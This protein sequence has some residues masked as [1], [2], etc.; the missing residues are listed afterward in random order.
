MRKI[1]MLFVIGFL[2]LN[3]SGFSQ[4]VVK[5]DSVAYEKAKYLKEDLARFLAK[6]TRYPISKKFYWDD[7]YNQE[8]DV[9]FS[10]VINKNSELENLTLESSTENIL[11]ECAIEAL[12]KL[13]KKWS[14]TKINHIS[15]DKKYKIIFRFRSFLDS[16]PPVYEKEIASLVKRHQYDK[17]IKLYDEQIY[18]NPCDFE[19]FA[20]RSKLKGKSGDKIGTIE[21][22]KWADK[23]ND[24]Y[25]SVVNVFVVGT[26][27][28][29]KIGDSPA[30]VWANQY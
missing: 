1:L 23:L 7:K 30:I 16:K 5:I 29:R 15:I 21:D 4:T 2:T 14:P 17:A 19:L 11:A 28:L 3:L 24:E 12:K 18:F 6:N 8:G 10:F 26:T 25:M 20:E 27:S 22:Y 13:D 9:I